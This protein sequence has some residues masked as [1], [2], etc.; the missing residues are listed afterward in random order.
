MKEYL[1]DAVHA[2]ITSLG[3]LELTTEDGETVAN[4]IILEPSVI[5]ALGVYLAAFL[6]PHLLK[7]M[8]K[9]LEG[10]LV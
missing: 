9:D 5:L 2:D 4:R 3:D 8:R 1:G 7:R 10:A 6:P